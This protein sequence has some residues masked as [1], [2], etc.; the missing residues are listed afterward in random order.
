MN[1]FVCT[2]VNYWCPSQLDS[3]HRP[4]QVQFW[5][6]F[7]TIP[8]FIIACKIVRQE[9]VIVISGPGLLLIMYTWYTAQYDTQFV[10]GAQANMKQKL[11]IHRVWAMG[12]ILHNLYM[13]HRPNMKYLLCMLYWLDMIQFGAWSIYLV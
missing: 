12:S 9:A 3:T 2:G 10:H 7:L 8:R 6:K 11:C 5:S 1:Y 13:K 4:S